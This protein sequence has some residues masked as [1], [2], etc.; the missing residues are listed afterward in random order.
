ME[1]LTK[2]K[3]LTRSVLSLV[4]IVLWLAISLD[5]PSAVAKVGTSLSWHSEAEGVLARGPGGRQPA[6]NGDAEDPSCLQ[7]NVFDDCMTQYCRPAYDACAAALCQP[8]TSGCAGPCISI[9][10]AEGSACVGACLDLQADPRCVEPYM[11]AFVECAAGCWSSPAFGDCGNACLANLEASR[12]RCQQGPVATPTPQSTP[13]PVPSATPMPQSTP[14][15]AASPTSSGGGVPLPPDFDGDGVFDSDDLCRFRAG[16]KELGGCPADGIAAGDLV[17]RWGSPARVALY[18]GY[19]ESEGRRYNF[20]HVGMYAGDWEA[21]RR[22]QVRHAEGLVVRRWNPTT[23][24]WDGFVLQEGE[25]VEPDDV[26][27]DAVIEGDIDYGGVGIS[28]L[29]NFRFDNKD[30]GGSRSNLYYGRPVGGLTV[31]QRRNVI[32]SMADFAGDTEEGEHEFATFSTNCA[33][34]TARAYTLWG[35]FPEWLSHVEVS[36]TWT[37]NYVASWLHLVPFPQ[38]G[39]VSDTETQP[40]TSGVTVYYDSSTPRV[41]F[42]LKSPA[43]LHVYDSSGRHTG[44]VPGGYE[45]QIPYSEYWE[46]ENGHKVANILWGAT[47]SYRME[48][49]SYSQGSCTLEVE[50]FN[51][52][53]QDQALSA[54]YEEVALEPQTTAQVT[55][56]PG[57]PPDEGALIL[58]VDEDGDGQPDRQERPSIEQFGGRPGGS[59][60]S[61]EETL[62]GSVLGLVCVGAF[63]GVVA[64]VALIVALVAARGRRCLFVV[65]LILAVPGFC[66]AAS[67]CL[68]AAFLA[69]TGG[70]KAPDSSAA[71]TVTAVLQRATPMASPAAT[72]RPPEV[73]LSPEEILSR[74]AGTMSGVTSAHIVFSQEDVGNYTASGEGVVAL[75]DRA[76]FDK[77]SSYDQSPVET[78]VIGSTGYWVDES[79]SGGWNSGP[80]APFA[81]NP[82]RWVGLLQFYQN[83]V[84]VGEETVNGVQCYHLEFEVSLEPGWMGLFS[85]GGTGQ[86]WVSAADFVLVRAVYD[87]QYEGSRESATMHL[88]LELSEVN[89]PVDIEAPR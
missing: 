53:G 34:T 79:V 82:A 56:V 36:E 60:R 72:A 29:E 73:L 69:M 31:E 18:T 48:L 54:H 8:T 86:A 63:A 10:T 21:D 33:Y 37:P 71:T 22:Y 47:D 13:P 67:T 12:D 89:E 25:Y 26:V 85:G 17:F 42:A 24:V 3:W 78:I 7:A 4:A 66:V 39:G 27:P 9:Y 44:P 76:H 50:S 65:L 51:Y 16:V 41:S 23:G 83:P 61:S 87:L 11:G 32:R 70:E 59:D 75:P 49:E 52:W 6:R 68:G 43:D 64:V 5:P 30:T 74:S 19:A 1:L 14:P 58:Q 55:L 84:L 77:I 62:F 15:P 2:Y 40:A 28:N 46:V 45:A 38:V 20:G 35:G 80:I 88:D 81:S 57:A